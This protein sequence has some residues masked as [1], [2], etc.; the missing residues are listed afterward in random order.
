M[1]T[2][3]WRVGVFLGLALFVG[4]LESAAQQLSLSGTVDDT[5]G[6]VPSVP[7]TLR[8]STGATQSATTDAE[9]RYRFENLKAD[10][11]DVSAAK[12]GF[13]TAT[14]AVVLTTRPDTVNLTLTIAGIVTSVDVFDVGGKST[15]SG[16]YIPIRELP[17]QVSV[18]S[19]ATIR[20]QG[21]TDLPGALENVSGVLMRVEYGVYEYMAIGGVS[22][23]GLFVDGLSLTGNRTNALINNVEQVE[24]LKGPN[25]VLYGGA[26]GSLGGIVNIVRK[27]PQ[28]ER[29]TEGLYKMGRWN[30]Q[31][32]A[33]GTSGQ[34]FNVPRLL[35]RLDAA[36]AH[37]DGWRQAGSKRFNVTPAL[38]WMISDRM[39]VAFNESFSRDRYRMDAGIPYTLLT[40][41][42]DYP[43]DRRFNPATD[44]QLTR[45]WQNQVVF[46]ANFT[47][48]FQFRN[49]F[50]NRIARDQYLDAESL[51]YNATTDM[52]TR[53]ELYFQHNR[54]PISNR[55]DFLGD[56]NTGALRHRFMVG[57]AF[58]NQ[59]NYTNRIGNAPGASNAGTVPI[60]SINVNDFLRDGF[61]DPAPT[62]TT[63]PRSRVD[64][65]TNR[66]HGV[67][68]Q[69]QID[70]TSRLRVNL[71]GRFDHYDRNTHN[72]VWNNDVFVSE[73]PITLFEQKKYSDRYGAVYALTDAH[74]IYV[75]SATQFSPNF[76]IPADGS[77]LEPTSA[78]SF[79]VGHKFETARG[80]LTAT[81]AFRRVLET[82]K[83]I[84]LGA[85]LF[86]QAGKAST[87]AFDFDLE[88]SLGRGFRAVASYGYADPTYDLFRQGTGATA[89]DLAGNQQQLA[90]HHTARVWGTKSLQLSRRASMTAGLGG[91]Y[92][93]DYFTNAIN[94][95]VL[96]SRL[97]FD[98]VVS[99]RVD[100]LDVAVNLA[101]LTNND[102]YFVSNI[103]SGNQFYP[104][105]PFNAT[106]TVR[107]RF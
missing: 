105:Q 9:G 6:V 62:Y 23:A 42:P 55:A 89:I 76:Q 28:A 65:S 10:S 57:Y 27:K 72:D 91:R 100:A 61:V 64:H 54:R 40:T 20:E 59:Y 99:F 33:L 63:F 92:V 18:V 107:Y 29:A 106:V 13:T 5:Y 75:V 30:T 66:I 49:T 104:G 103:N 85:G 82:N 52:L 7:V 32:V 93:G 36:F 77:T 25:A 22:F 80:R 31:H 58:D 38:T 50:F 90:P 26:S 87:R 16:M 35:Y 79:E 45:D 39:R 53:G 2:R 96:P 19:A 4:T 43:L 98:G 34:V 41:R 56:F 69:D 97:T 71:A 94:T 74:R 44:F 60:P 8:A 95:I 86:T 67:A 15:A 17:S 84:G 14:R 73:G 101:N 48:R 46:H 88:G 47:D 78:R 102:R 83:V 3:Y 51:S 68:W 21:I 1:V 12:E 70:L 11:Y 81:T 24:V 37:S